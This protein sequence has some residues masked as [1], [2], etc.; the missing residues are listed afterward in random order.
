MGNKHSGRGALSE[1]CRALAE[2][3]FKEID[4]DGSLT[5]DMEETAKWWSQN[6]AIVNSRAMF[7]NVDRDRNGAIDFSEWMDF[8]ALVKH[9]GYSDDEIFEELTNLK[10][11]GSWVQFIGTQVHAKAKD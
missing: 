8:W 9:Q 3:I 10:N 4:V 1:R 6:F 11:R 2:E 5:I 7:E